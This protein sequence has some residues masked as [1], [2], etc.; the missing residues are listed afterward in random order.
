MILC[1][2]QILLT[3]EDGTGL[4]L[5]KSSHLTVDL[6]HQAS[7]TCNVGRVYF[8]NTSCNV[9]GNCAVYTQVT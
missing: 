8:C 5:G 2:A 1:V 3:L 7:S 6:S 4:Q 9:R